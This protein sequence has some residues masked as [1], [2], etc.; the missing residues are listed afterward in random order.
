MIQGTELGAFI[1][2]EIHPSVAAVQKLVRELSA[3]DY[4]L[5]IAR[6]EETPAAAAR[7]LALVKDSSEFGAARQETLELRTEVDSE[8]RQNAARST[9]LMREVTGFEFG[10]DTYRVFVT[11]PSM[12]N[13][14]YFGNQ[15]IA[16]GGM[17]EW[18]NYRTVYLWHEIL[19][20]EKWLGTGELNH[21]V[22]ELVADNELRVRLNG[23][24]YPPWEGHPSLTPI[25]E[26]I[27]PQWREYLASPGKDL[28]AFL[29]KVSDQEGKT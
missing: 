29:A 17:N 20:D 6:S 18:P 28:R 10:Q 14:A 19:H 2:N 8:W 26:R 16:W 22:L 11:H 7:L 9:A 15:E 4:S 13:G 21:A 23:G 3:V 1:E 12:R 25:R 24:E 5:V 27:L